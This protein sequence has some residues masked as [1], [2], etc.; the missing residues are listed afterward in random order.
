MSIIRLLPDSVRS[1]I[2]AGEVIVNPGSAI[3]ELI[4]NALDAGADVIKV[5]TRKGGKT[6]IKVI[7]NGSGMGADDLLK[8]VERHYTSKIYSDSD[9]YNIHSLGFRGEALSS[10]AVVGNLSIASQEKDEGIELSFDHKGVPV[11]KKKVALTKGTIVT[12]TSLFS[13]MPVRLRYLSS[14]ETED[15]NNLKILYRFILSNPKVRFEFTSGKGTLVFP[16]SKQIDRI[17]MVF[18]RD[19]SDNMVEITIS[20]P[21]DKDINV[22]GYITKPTYSRKTKEYQYIYVNGRYIKSKEILDLI[23]QGY[24]QY[25]KLFLDRNPCFVLN[26]TIPPEYIDLHIHP[27]K[28]EVKFIKDVSGIQ[29][30]IFKCLKDN[31]NVLDVTT[32]SGSKA[33]TKNYYD[34]CKQLTLSVDKS[35]QRT[36]VSPDSNKPTS[37]GWNKFLPLTVIDIVNK[38]YILCSDQMGLVLVDQHASEERVNFEKLIKQFKSKTVQVQKLLSPVTIVTS[39]DEYGEIESNLAKFKGLGFDLEVYGQE[40][41]IL[42]SMPSLLFNVASHDIQQ[43]ILAMANKFNLTED[44]L[45][46]LVAT[47]ACRMSI[48]GGDVISKEYAVK[49]LHSLDRCDNPYTCPHGRPT[50]I[51]FTWSDLEKK[52]KRRE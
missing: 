9:L 1:K 42:R 29:D 2:A 8:S 7:D 40:T 41:F 24:D 19:V 11:D 46:N 16:S 38:M 49:L 26:I 12:L 47:K 3:K 20:C 13:E 30:L 15:R 28:L 6:L 14:D 35:V 5:I 17:S 23:Y 25:G 52:F 43:L 44:R 4:E 18:G 33:V 37:D 34:S 51:R 36:N 50:L 31:E 10:M 22:S 21:I 48:K 27:A 39:M 45:Y 32:K